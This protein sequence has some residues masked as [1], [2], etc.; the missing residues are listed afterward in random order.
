MFAVFGHAQ[1]F[2]VFQ[3]LYTR[4]R[5]AS[6]SAVSWIGSVQVFLIIALALPAGKL[7]DR[8]H[9]RALLAAGT[10]VFSFSSP[11]LYPRHG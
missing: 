4:E 2:G 7:V 11:L 10:L 8:G 3:D 9:F 6:A 1:A 5:T